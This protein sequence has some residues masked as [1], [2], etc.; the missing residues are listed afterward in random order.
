MLPGSEAWQMTVLQPAAVAMRAA[1]S[2]VLIPPLPQPE[3]GES[4]STCVLKPCYVNGQQV[5]CQSC[6]GQF[7]WINDMIGC[8]QG[9]FR[10]YAGLMNV[11]S[12]RTLMLARSCTSLMGSASGLRAGLLVYRASTSVKRNSQSACTAVATCMPCA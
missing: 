1:V 8:M 11:S 10:E 7:T 9:H 2:F 6:D 3:P 5:S 4:V 12:D